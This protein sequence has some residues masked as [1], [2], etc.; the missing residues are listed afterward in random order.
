MFLP[1]CLSRGFWTNSGRPRGS[2]AITDDDDDNGAENFVA[3]ADERAE[4]DGGGGGGGAGM[5]PSPTPPP[6]FHPPLPSSPPRRGGGRGG[7][8]APPAGPNREVIMCGLTVPLIQVRCGRRRHWF[9]QV[10][11]VGQPRYR[12]SAHGLV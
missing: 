11:R 5:A 10:D 4:L 12:R 2:S 3:A 7:D 9:G 1:F 6:L 8:H